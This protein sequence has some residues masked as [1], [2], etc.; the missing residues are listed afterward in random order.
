M[1]GNEV[2]FL[3]RERLDCKYGLFRKGGFF[4]LSQ[5]LY[6]KNKNKKM[7]SDFFE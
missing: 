4:T 1:G 2:F 7:P 6:K 5:N 3:E